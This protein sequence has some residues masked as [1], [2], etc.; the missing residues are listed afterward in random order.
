[1]R[2]FDVLV[3]GTVQADD[4]DIVAKVGFK[5]PYIMEVV[6]EVTNAVEIRLQAV[7]ENPKISGI[8]VIQLPP[9]TKSLTKATSAAPTSSFGPGLSIALLIALYFGL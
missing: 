3:G 1:M 8:E 5:A 7:I 9:L 4:L 6:Q 2:I